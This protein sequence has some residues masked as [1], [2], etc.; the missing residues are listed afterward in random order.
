MVTLIKRVPS[1]P[2]WD[3]QEKEW[4]VKKESV[5]YPP[6]RDA[7]WYVEAFA[8]W[9]VAKRFVAGISRHSENNDVVYEIP[10]M[11]EFSGEHYMLLNPYQY[12]LE[13]V[14]YALDHKRCIFGDQPG[15]GKTLQAICSVVKAHNEASHLW[16]SECDRITLTDL[17]NP[18]RNDATTAAHHVSISSAA[19]LCIPAQ[20]ALCHSDFLLDSLGDT[21]GINGI[22]SLVR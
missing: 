3:A 13:G 5:C 21:H 1:S 15:L 19:N 18:E 4:I 11:K 17:V 14:R 16:L 10:P 9:A 2:K 20:T 8:Q 6:D 7:R 22:S 12:Q